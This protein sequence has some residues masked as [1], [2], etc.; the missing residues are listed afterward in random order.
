MGH[1]IHKQEAVVLVRDFYLLF[2]GQLC[3]WVLIF[4]S[5]LTILCERTFKCYVEV[6]W[7]VSK[8]VRNWFRI[9]HN[10]LNI[11]FVSQTL[12]LDLADERSQSGL[13]KLNYFFSRVLLVVYQHWFSLSIFGASFYQIKRCPVSHSDSVDSAK[14]CIFLDHIDN[15][16]GIWDSSVC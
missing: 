5:E 13:K 12:Q 9:W 16:L 2:V 15:P 10:A 6:D 11:F 7:L 14:F 1:L 3:Y 8:N 4:K